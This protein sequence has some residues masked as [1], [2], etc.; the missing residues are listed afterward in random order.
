MGEVLSDSDV[1]EGWRVMWCPDCLTSLAWED[2]EAAEIHE[3]QQEWFEVV[4]WALDEASHGS[5]E[6]WLESLPHNHR[7][8]C[9]ARHIRCA[10]CIHIEC[11]GHRYPTPREEFEVVF[12]PVSDDQWQWLKEFIERKYI[13]V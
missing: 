8:T 2:D 11:G 10:S 13:N 7:C 6:G 9:H 5:H 1:P 12:G 3:L 4:S